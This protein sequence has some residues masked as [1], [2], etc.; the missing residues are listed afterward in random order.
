MKLRE[1]KIDDRFIHASSKD[2]LKAD[3]YKVTGACVFNGGHGTSTRDCIN[4]SKKRYESK[5]CN[6]EVK[7]LP[8]LS[9]D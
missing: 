1:L 3:K 5:S 7:K 8:L 9:E 2:V 4:E 6:L